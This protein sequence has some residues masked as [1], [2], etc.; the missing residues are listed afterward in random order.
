MGGGGCEL[1]P[2]PAIIVR[3]FPQKGPIAFANAGRVGSH[4][5]RP[6]GGIYGRALFS[7]YPSVWDQA[8][9]ASAMDVPKATERSATSVGSKLNADFIAFSRESIAATSVVLELTLVKKLL[10]NSAKEA[11]TLEGQ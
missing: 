8:K 10:L 1:S 9:T 7:L 3:S 11:F 5:P 4:N 2:L 6:T